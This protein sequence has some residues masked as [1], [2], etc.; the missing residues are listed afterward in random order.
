MKSGTAILLINS[1]GTGGAEKAVTATAAR[2]RALGR[3]VRLVCMERVSSGE[4]LS[5]IQ[6][7][8]CLSN[9]HASSSSFLK[10]AALPVL[11]VRLRKYI[12]RNGVSV[13]MSHLFRA[14]FVNV[15]ARLLPACRHRAIL[16]NHTRLSRLRSEGARGWIDW[17]LCRLLYHRA[18]VVASASTGAARECARLLGLPTERSVTLYDAIDISTGARAGKAPVQARAMVAVGRLVPLKR[19]DDLIR[20][21]REIAPEF[22]EL[23]LHLIGDGPARPSLERLADATGIG[24]RIRFLGRLADPA[25]VV[26]GCSVFVSSSAVEGFGMAI[27]EAL[28]AGVPV[29]AADC[30]YGPREILAPSTDPMELLTGDA[31]PEMAPFGLL[32]PVG[33]VPAL[34]K[35]LRQILCDPLLAS[36]LARKG[37]QRAADFSVE[38][39]ATAYERLLFPG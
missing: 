8:E 27:V 16:V 32:Y 17:I 13:V 22:P 26:A 5:G 9:L 7:S 30:A 4:E 2:L 24:A 29:V 14:N 37:P 25:P 6:A 31:E 36:S 1:L 39:S 11:A 12:R 38:R 28:A 15:L 33:S 35:A 3:D 10:L 19:F 18:D 23:E 21:F 34:K 20:A